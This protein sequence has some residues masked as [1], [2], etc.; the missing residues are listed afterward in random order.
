M[1][2]ENFFVTLPKIFKN[3]RYER[4]EM[5]H[6]SSDG[7]ARGFGGSY[8]DER[9][10]QLRAARALSGCSRRGDA[11]YQRVDSGRERGQNVRRVGR[12]NLRR[13]GLSGGLLGA[14]S[15]T[16]RLAGI[17]AC[18]VRLPTARRLFQGARGGNLGFEPRN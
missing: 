14:D 1:K 18:G 9:L 8:A 16:E 12:G 10:V 11:S 4:L 2:D 13:T 5:Y 17:R 6:P 3:I 15:R 7:R